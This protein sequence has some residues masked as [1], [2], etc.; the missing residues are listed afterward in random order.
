M[1]TTLK[2]YGYVRVA[3]VSPELRVA[4]VTFNVRKILEAIEQADAQG[5][6]I[7]VFPELC[8]TGYSCADL[9]YQEVLLNEAL[10]ALDAI[11]SKTQEL[12]TSVVVGLPVAV[13]S[14]LYNCAAFVSGGSV[15][16][17]VPKSYLPSTK[18][19]YEERWFTSGKNIHT[20]TVVFKGANVPFGTD[21]I[22]RAS[23]IPSCAIG[24]EI[25]EDL[26]AV[27]PPSGGL[28]VAGA[29]L[30]AN[31]SAS[32]ELLGK[33]K[34]RRE[35]ICQ[36]SAR[37][38]AAYL[39]AGAGPGESSTDTVFG[40]HCLV[41]ENGL[42]LEETERFRFETQ[43]AIA[44]VDLQRLVNERIGNS[45]YSSDCTSGSYQEVCFELGEP[46][47]ASNADA[48]L[49]RPI[50][51][52]PFVPCDRAE[53]SRN[54]EEIFAIQ[55]TGLAKRIR[56]MGVEKALI[57][58]SGGLDSTLAL[59]VAIRAF[60]LINLPRSGIIGVMMPGFGTSERTSSNAEGLLSRLGV[61]QRLVSVQAAVQQHF[62]DI[63]HDENDHDTTFE[64]SQARE[65]T[66]ILMDMAN[67]YNGLVIGTGDL[68]E[69]AL[70]WCTYNGDHMSMYHVN[71]GV[72]KTLVRSLI[73]WCADELFDKAVSALLADVCDT[74]I[75][76]ELLPLGDDGSLTQ[77][78]EEVI[79]PYEL[80]DFFLFYVVRHQ[81]PPHKIAFLAENAFGND[82]STDDIRSW[83]KVFYERFFSQQF[84][85]SAMPD[86][87]K[88]GT[89]AL[90]P[91]ADWRMPSDVR[92]DL[93]LNGEN[94]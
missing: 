64:N 70:G 50:P 6:Q 44:D 21:L 58:V 4:D 71:S 78:T 36:Q 90:S 31:P 66:Q 65:R 32:N 83:L 30:I 80:H 76:P 79:G 22:F 57:G 47:K 34:Y 91:R 67:K 53:R 75:T 46:Q 3:V 73:E 85:R 40:G 63:G 82:Y 87:P 45:A 49:K 60:D 54:C 29:T 7:T 72:P 9:F 74:P 1:N 18:E 77:K 17:V 86:G 5:A 43:L 38:M 27:Q 25:C 51:R 84:K 26:W 16:G 56:H 68:S 92:P 48:R 59:L 12:D 41:V 10:A 62:S 24:I 61:S 14:H 28:A 15:V 69:L 88:V 33:V 93:W 23:N 8:V 2:D 94:E 52:L 89:V 11:V 42:I 20:D 55:S 19:Y 37:C 13:N 81:F 39:Y 35:L